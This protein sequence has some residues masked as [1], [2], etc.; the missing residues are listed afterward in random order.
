MTHHARKPGIKALVYLTPDSA[1][2]QQC[3]LHFKYSKERDQATVSLEFSIS[4]FDDEQTFIFQYDANNLV[5]GTTKLGPV[6]IPLPQVLLSQL[7]R[8]AVTDMRTLS[9][10]LKEACPIWCPSFP[11]ST[12]PKP[13]FDTDFHQLV[14]LAKAKQVYILLDLNWLHKVHLPYFQRFTK[15][16]GLTGFPVEDHYKKTHRLVDWRAF[17]PIDDAQD[18]P[19]YAHI[20][21]KRPNQRSESSVLNNH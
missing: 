10:S 12:T 15:Q 21:H 3:S 20:S 8:H 11:G 19:S 1:S 7:K 9:L 18:L 2:Q 17:S 14:N 13:G 5:P 4:G 16:K 6:D